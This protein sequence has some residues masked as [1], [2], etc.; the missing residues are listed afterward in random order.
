MVEKQVIIQ[1]RIDEVMKKE[2]EKLIKESSKDPLIKLLLENKLG[3]M[4]LE[5]IKNYLKRELN[6]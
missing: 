4:T 2:F 1:K 6:E 3:L 5:E